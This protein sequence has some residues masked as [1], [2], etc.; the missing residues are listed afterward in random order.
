M[1]QGHD[2][3]EH[4]ADEG[5]WQGDDVQ[6]EEPVQRDLRHQVVAADP[7]H[8]IRPDERYGTDQRN[9]HLGAP[10]G[11][12]A[13]RQQ[14]AEEA[15]RHQHEV[16]PHADEPK[17]FPGRAVRAVGE[18]P[19]HVQIDHYEE[20]RSAGRV[21]VADDVA[22]FDVPHDVLHRGER[23][24]PARHVRHRQP[25]AGQQLDAEHDGRE[26]PEV[27]PEVEV[28]RRV[29]LR[30]VVLH[31]FRQR[32][33]RVQPDQQARQGARGRRFSH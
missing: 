22:V 23:A 10:E 2:V 31:R 4:Q 9:N 19:E 20:R 3:Q 1:V 28:L 33:A 16:D 30:G 5:Q 24:L 12:V 8:E 14:V 7:L 17:Q 6:G 25:D 32:Q 11:H 21:H 29:V 18:P 15:L 13:P 27:V 26:D